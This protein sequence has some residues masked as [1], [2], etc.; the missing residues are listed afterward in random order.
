MEALAGRL[1]RLLGAAV[2]EPDRSIGSLD[3]PVC[4]RA[5]HHPAGLE[6]DGSC[7]IAPARWSICLPA[8]VARC[9]QAVAVVYEDVRLSYRELDERSSRLAHHLR[10]LSVGP[11]VVV[12]LCVERSPEMIV[13]LLGILK[14]G[15]AYLPLDP[16]YPA[17][18]L[19]FMLADA[20]GAGAGDAGRAAGA[21]AGATAAR[22][23]RLDA[24][25][26]AIAR[27]PAHAPD[28]ALDPHHPAYVIY[29]SGSTGSPKGVV[30]THGKH[31]QSYG[32]DDG[33]PSGRRA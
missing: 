21:A 17:E 2:A 24:D 8:Q 7:A 26:P 4:G 25:W 30:V 22:S 12:G 5:A 3:D 11:E 18:R 23:V 32:V 9:P 33:R 20:G 29:T 14:A 19:A 16:D 1:E 27:H 6:R 13:G 31:R 28:L 10:A 15:G